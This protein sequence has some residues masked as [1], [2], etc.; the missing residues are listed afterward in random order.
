MGVF[1]LVRDW[2]DAEPLV[3]PLPLDWNERRQPEEEVPGVL[4]LWS[5]VV[6][7]P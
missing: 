2:I 3:D 5:D 1:P 7:F 6:L 4:V